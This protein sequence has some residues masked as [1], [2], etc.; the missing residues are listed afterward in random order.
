[1]V[2][3]FLVM[4]AVVLESLAVGK[5]SFMVSIEVLLSKYNC[6]FLF[7]FSHKIVSKFTTS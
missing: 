7:W 5:G 4:G 2:L 1:M 6:P 3:G